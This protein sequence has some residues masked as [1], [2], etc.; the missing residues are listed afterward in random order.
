[1]SSAVVLSLVM[2]VNSWRIRQWT[3]TQKR[4]DLKIAVHTPHKLICSTLL[5]IGNSYDLN[6]WHQVLHSTQWSLNIFSVGICTNRVIPVT[7]WFLVIQSTSHVFSPSLLVALAQESYQWHHDSKVKHS[8]NCVITNGGYNT[9]TLTVTLG[10]QVICS[11]HCVSNLYCW[12]LWLLTS[13][14]YG[15]VPSPNLYHLCY[16]VYVFGYSSLRLNQFSSLV[17]WS[18]S[19]EINPNLQKYESRALST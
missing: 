13:A 4:Y 19:W 7:P 1:M 9:L 8:V 6:Q 11:T 10:H 15:M 3:C 14:S 5:A 16:P 17:L 18:V 12:W 2:G